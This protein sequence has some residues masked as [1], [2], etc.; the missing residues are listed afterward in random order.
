[1]EPFSTCPTAVT[2][3]IVKLSA[4]GTTSLKNFV[5][6][7]LISIT[8]KNEKRCTPSREAILGDTFLRRE[9][10]NEL[11]QKLRES[12]CFFIQIFEESELLDSVYWNRSPVPKICKWFHNRAGGES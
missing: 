5:R 9:N 8:Q 11:P 3:T 6:I 1:M 12:A 2:V 10:A 4:I 7:S